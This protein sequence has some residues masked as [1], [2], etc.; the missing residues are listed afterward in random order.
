[1]TPVPGGGEVV[2]VLDG[3]LSPQ[4]CRRVV[5]ELEFALW[6]RSQVAVPGPGGGLVGASSP[7]RTSESTGQRWFSEPLQALVEEL[8]TRLCGDFGALPSHLEPWQAVRYGPGGRFG[9]HTDGGPFRLEPAGDR[10]L[11]F[12]LCVQAPEGGGGTYFPRLD[13]LVDAVA[14]RLLVW[15][16]LLPDGRPDERTLH[17]ATPARAGRKVVLTTW[18][19]ERPVR[20]PAQSAAAS[21]EAARASMTTAM[22]ASS[23]RQAPG[24]ANSGRSSAAP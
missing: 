7:E 4:L 24:R 1:M 13:R 2:T 6:R 16:N 23:T 3:Y 15:D 18:S 9:L 21:S 19:R 8:G 10:V 20:P 17:A 11:T 14:G 22:P 12:L 5:A